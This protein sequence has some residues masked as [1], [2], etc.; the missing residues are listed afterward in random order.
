MTQEPSNDSVK[1]P[2]DYR[3]LL[4][5]YP[6]YLKIA[7]LLLLVLA[8]LVPLTMIRGIV[9]ERQSR[10]DGV[11]AELHQT[12]G[13]P[14]S[15]VGPVLVLP[16]DKP[17]PVSRNESPRPQHSYSRAEGRKADPLVREQ[18]TI[19]SKDLAISSDVRVQARKRGIY[20]ALVFTADTKVTG[21][22][23]LPESAAFDIKEGE[24][25]RWK[26]ARLEFYVD[27]ISAI[28]AADAIVWNGKALPLRLGRRLGET[29]GVLSAD[30][31]LPEPGPES[32][33]GWPGAFTLEITTNGSGQVDFHPLGRRTRIDV[34]ADWP[35][36]S[37]GGAF[38]PATTEID[39]QGFTAAWEL[40][41][42]ARG[43]PQ[44]WRSDDPRRP[45]LFP[46]EPGSAA[47]I[48]LI[49]PVSHYLKAERAVK[50]GILFVALVC[51]IVF[52]IEALS[53][54]RIHVI[55]YG[56]VAA[57]LCLF[58]LLLLSLSEVVGFARAYLLATVPSIALIAWYLAKV[59]A[60]R[61]NGVVIG[62]LLG[63]V[64]GYLF[65][66]LQAEDQAL[67]LGSLLLLG[68]LAVTMIATRN[69]DWYALGTKP[70]RRDVSQAPKSLQQ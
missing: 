31:A 65:A 20:Q 57:A 13:G 41:R 3:G 9:L 34:T 53:G 16:F 22:F 60:S 47:V 52:V 59:T 51:G 42:F 28:D 44:H 11:V 10:H 30:L 7:G 46:A 17:R 62:G 43:L 69:I 25:I 35:H 19:L 61:R 36:P 1:T 68:A 2:H 58:F 50:Y 49:E 55:Q 37:F 38:L 33:K 66:T 32:A 29:G 21:A 63:A 8:S 26:A 23:G 39:D 45:K 56:F 67:L 70:H 64:Y 27:N 6:P 14:Q 18:I 48:G 15:L 12:W 54:G 24:T 5:R 4:R 40:S